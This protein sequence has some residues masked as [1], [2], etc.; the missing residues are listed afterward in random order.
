MSTDLDRVADQP[1]PRHP[2]AVARRADRPG[3][4]RLVRRLLRIPPRTTTG[5]PAAER[6]FQTSLLVSAV[7]CLLTYVV[8][9]F[10]APAL[11]LAAG[12][13][14]SLGIV[15]G[16]VAVAANIVSIRRFWSA[17]HRL[18]WPFSAVALCVIGLL[19]VLLG[20]DIAALLG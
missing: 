14:P 13:G 12:V 8:L 19:L 7:R 3:A 15:I 9:P 17:D 5:A 16:L 20:Q 1:A 4:D 6:A 11:G 18:R 10:V 2:A